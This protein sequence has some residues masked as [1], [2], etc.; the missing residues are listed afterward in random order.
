MSGG[1]SKKLGWAWK[2]STQHCSRP[3]HAAL[4]TLPG[5]KRGEEGGLLMFCARPPLCS[6]TADAPP[7]PLQ[8]AATSAAP[9]RAASTLVRRVSSTA[10]LARIGSM[11]SA[12]VGGIP[13]HGSTLR[14]RRL[15]RNVIIRGQAL[16]YAR[17]SI[18]TGGPT[19]H[20]RTV[21]D[22]PQSGRLKGIERNDYQYQPYVGLTH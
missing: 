12:P 17:D 5:A 13:W 21:M 14:K 8:M 19:S 20:A 7:P 10:P 18:G 9:P 1:R 3:A 11:H 4:S 2:P 15:T 16:F 6:T 22:I